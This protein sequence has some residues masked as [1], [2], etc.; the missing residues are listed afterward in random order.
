MLLILRL[1]RFHG[2]FRSVELLNY[3]LMD[4]IDEAEGV[5]RVE[6]VLPKIENTLV[7]YPFKLLFLELL[8]LGFVDEVA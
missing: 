1:I 3:L 6:V 7:M 4:T 8:A 2:V 5:C